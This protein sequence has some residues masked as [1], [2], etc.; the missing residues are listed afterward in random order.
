MGLPF[1][2]LFWH[3]ATARVASSGELKQTKPKP[4]LLPWEAKQHLLITLIQYGEGCNAIP[5]NAG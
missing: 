5:S 2:I 4:L 1:H 3:S